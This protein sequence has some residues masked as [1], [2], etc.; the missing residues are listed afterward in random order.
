MHVSILVFGS[1]H[2]A[3]CVSSIGAVSI[4]EMAQMGIITADLVGGRFDCCTNDNDT[5]ARCWPIFAAIFRVRVWKYV[6]LI[7]ILNW[8][9]SYLPVIYSEVADISANHF[10]V[11]IYIKTHMRATSFLF[12]IFT[13]YLVHYIKEHKISF[14]KTTQWFMWSSSLVIGCASMVSIVLFFGVQYSPISRGLYAALHRLGWSYAT[15]WV[16]LACI[17]GYAGPIRSILAS[18]ALVPL[19]RL[20]Y[21]AYLMN[22]LVELYQAASIRS[23][24]YMS[25]L[26]LFGETTSHILITFLGAMVLCL[27]FES[28][29]H[30]IEKIF[31]RKGKT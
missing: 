23:P 17:L 27:I 16:L 2:A 20:T 3:I 13:G 26:N 15:S 25:V 9:I 28:P 22:G 5:V 31:L 14:S 18:T 1:W 11:S 21:C 7:W 30:G 8:S 6:I 29:I 4:V 19:S 12:G 24:K 10:F